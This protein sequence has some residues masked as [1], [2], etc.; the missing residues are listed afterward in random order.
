MSKE[1]F[2]SPE[3]VRLPLSGGN[4][5]DVKKRLNAGEARRVFTRQLK[6]MHLGEKAELDPAQ[7][8]RSRLEEY[9]VGWSAP[10]AYT[11]DA[12][13]NLTPARYAELV[14]VI[15]THD[16]AVDAAVAV[17]KNAPGGESTLP[18]LSPSAAS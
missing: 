1:W 14:A 18:A 6:T 10:A 7:V 17:E 3:V 5:V 16:E 4:W 9:I 13:E 12:L 11:P 2:V 8:G 15:D